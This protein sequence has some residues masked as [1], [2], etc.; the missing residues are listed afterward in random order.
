MGFSLHH[1]SELAN[2]MTGF[3]ISLKPK[4]EPTAEPRFLNG[5]RRYTIF[6]IRMN[7]F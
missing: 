1:G 3:K 7:I 5:M 4:K 6:K 2:M